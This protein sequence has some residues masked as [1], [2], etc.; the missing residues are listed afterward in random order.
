[1]DFPL[2]LETSIWV[3]TRSRLEVTSIN[4]GLVREVTLS[5]LN[6]WLAVPRSDVEKSLKHAMRARHSELTQESRAQIAQ[7]VLGIAV[8]Y[9]R[10]Q[11]L[12]LGGGNSNI[13][14]FHPENWGRFPFWL[15]YVSK[16]LVQAPTRLRRLQRNCDALNL[17]DIW[18]RQDEVILFESTEVVPLAL[19]LA[20][21]WSVPQWMAENW[22]CQFGT[23]EAWLTFFRNI[24]ITDL[25]LGFSV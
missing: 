7:Q 8:A 4:W 1:M 9:G 6:Q 17:L 12:L 13:L 3:Q 2:L 10:L 23:M 18:K 11:H 14:D 15:I 21:T 16:G 22:L 25:T 24:Y 20:I 19:R 5:A